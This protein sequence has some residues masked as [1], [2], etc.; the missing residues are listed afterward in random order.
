MGS[1]EF[2]DREKAQQ[3]LDKIGEPALDAL[4]SASKSDDTE[5]RR[6]SSELVKKIERRVES[7]SVLRPTMAHLV[8]K[9]TPLAEALADFR[10]KSGFT[11]TLHDPENKL[12]DRK[13]T[14]DT[15]ETTFWQAFDE[16]SVP[17]RGA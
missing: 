11:I 5:I 2:D 14:L 13:I 1:S 7:I 12:K 8:Y 9:E 10:K 17:R 3:E 15:G 16:G 4:K 6:R